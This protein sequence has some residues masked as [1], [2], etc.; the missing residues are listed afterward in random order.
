MSAESMPMPNLYA[1]GDEFASAFDRW[2]VDFVVWLRAAGR[3]PT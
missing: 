3:G 1:T 2:L